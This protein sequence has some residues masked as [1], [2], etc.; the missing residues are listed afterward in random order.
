M[1]PTSDHDHDVRRGSDSERTQ[2]MA[3][4]DQTRPT[5]SVSWFGPEEGTE[6]PGAPAGGTEPS[7]GAEHLSYGGGQYG[8]GQ[9]AGQ[10]GGGQYGDQYGTQYG[11]P[12]YGSGQYG[13][14]QYG[15]GQYGTGQPGSYAASYPYPSGYEQQ[16]GQTQTSAP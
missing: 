7:Y 16:Y 4:A 10:Y 12:P 6:R 5:P 9:P 8:G 3:P 11:S 13:S 14:G 1:N 15:S 2:E